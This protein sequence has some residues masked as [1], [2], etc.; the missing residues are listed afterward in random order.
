M[1]PSVTEEGTQHVLALDGLDTFA[2]VK[3]NGQVI[4]ESDNMWIMHRV[5]VTSMLHADRTN[6]LE[7][8]L[9]PAL[10]AAKEIKDA[11]PEHRWVGF[12]GD[13]SRLAVRKVSL[14]LTVRVNRFNPA[15]TGSV[16]LGLGLGPYADDLWTVARC[17]ARDIPS[18]S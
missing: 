2:N 18:S 1:V 9:R 6:L 10:L 15:G 4:L 5:N 8:E 16:S 3:V 11:H 14:I 17:T 7:I 13:M 12:N